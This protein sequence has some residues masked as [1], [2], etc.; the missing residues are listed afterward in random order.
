[1]G[2]LRLNQQAQVLHWSV[3]CPLCICCGLQLAV[4]VRILTVGIDT[5]LSLLPN[6]KTF[7]M[8]VCFVLLQ[9]KDICLILLNFTIPCLLD[10]L[11]AFSFLMADGGGLDLL[12]MGGIGGDGRS[13]GRRKLLKYVKQRRI[14]F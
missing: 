11:E 5:S 10:L 2:S 7:I 1:M 14:N 8:L 3:L 6:L 4:F 12:Q 13:G 9:G